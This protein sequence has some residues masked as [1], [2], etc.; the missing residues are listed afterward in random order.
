MLARKS[1]RGVHSATLVRAPHI[2]RSP[3]DSTTR[4]SGLNGGFY[5]HSESVYD[6]MKFSGVIGVVVFLAD[7]GI[8]Y[9]SL[10]MSGIH[11]R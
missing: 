9:P 8:R 1:T 2:G 5:S 3:E 11:P 6:G 7:H 4:S 10:Q